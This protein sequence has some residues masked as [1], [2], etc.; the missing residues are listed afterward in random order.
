[1]IGGEP[2]RRVDREAE[3]DFVILAWAARFAFVTVSTLSRR[4]RVERSR[5]DPSTLTPLR[6]TWVQNHE[7]P[8]NLGFRRSSRRDLEPSTFCMASASG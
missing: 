8:G 7:R 2:G 6:K 5:N 3:L 1:L 4:C